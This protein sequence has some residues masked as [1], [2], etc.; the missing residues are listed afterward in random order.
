MFVES[1]DAFLADFGV[2]AELGSMRATVVLDAPD[3]NVL[4]DRAQSTAYAIV[5][6][7]SD[8]AGLNHGDAIVVDGKDYSVITVSNIDDGAFKRAALQ[9]TTTPH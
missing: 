1:L 7:A 5:F 6:K 3:A 2:I 9:R 4:G 8:L